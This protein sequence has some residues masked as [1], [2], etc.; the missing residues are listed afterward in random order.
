MSVVHV[1]ESNA[2]PILCKQCKLCKHLLSPS[3]S[4]DACKTHLKSTVCKSH[5]LVVRE[6]LIPQGLLL[7][8]AAA[9]GRQ[10]ASASNARRCCRQVSCGLTT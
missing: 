2:D 9:T 1:S 10:E 5:H 4:P 3:N 8:A 6:G 7:Q